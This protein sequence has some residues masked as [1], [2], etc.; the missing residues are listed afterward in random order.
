MGCQKLRVPG[1]YPFW[2]GE[3]RERCWCCLCTVPVDVYS[4]IHS[5][6]HYLVV[7]LI[8]LLRPLPPLTVLPT[9][10]SVSI[11]KET[12]PGCFFFRYLFCNRLETLIGLIEI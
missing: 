10:L 4:V 7:V 5:F 6:I 12:W 11:E 2:K 9:M 8:N 3:E 1:C